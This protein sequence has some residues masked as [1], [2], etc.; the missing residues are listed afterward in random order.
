MVGALVGVTALIPVAGAFIGAGVG[1]FIILTA[2]P[3]KAIV[4]L[5]FI[6]ILQ[7]LEENLIYPKVIGSKLNLSPIWILAAITVGGGIAG[8]LGMLV[9]VPATA[10]AYTLLKEATEKREEKRCNSVKKQKVKITE[11]ADK[12]G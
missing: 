1:A 11:K 4:F 12:N 8:A 9:S 2:A 3:V 6:L 5:I 10:T 7:Q